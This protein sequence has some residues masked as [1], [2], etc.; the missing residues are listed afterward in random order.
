MYFLIDGI[1]VFEALKAV[2][3]NQRVFCIIADGLKSRVDRNADRLI[4]AMHQKPLAKLDRQLLYD[5]IIKDGMSDQELVNRSSLP[6]ANFQDL[7]L[8]PHIPKH[9]YIEMQL[10]NRDKNALKIICRLSES[11]DLKTT[12]IEMLRRGQI[13]GD[14]AKAI[15]KVLKETSLNR[16][17]ND[18]MK[19]AAIIR[20]IED[21]RTF[22]E[23]DASYINLVVAMTQDPEIYYH[24]KDSWIAYIIRLL[25]DITQNIHPNLV[26]VISRND[27]GLLISTIEDLLL[28]F[29]WIASF[30]PRKKTGPGIRYRFIKFSDYKEKSEKE[31]NED[32]ISHKY[33]DSNL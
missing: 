26:H 2:N 8:D 5:E 32:Y 1:D 6:L 21:S 9:L 27:K 13:T 28:K 10:L 17:F 7:Q 19:M 20:A 3:P 18:E 30:E 31:G 25:S 15:N 12:L 23:N 29:G 14:G 16:K 24:H 11:E 33:T 22:N 4:M